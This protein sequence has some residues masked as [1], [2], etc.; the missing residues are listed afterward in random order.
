MLPFRSNLCQ[1]SSFLFFLFSMKLFS[2]SDSVTDLADVK[3]LCAGL[4]ALRRALGGSHQ[5]PSDQQLMGT[6]TVTL[7]DLQWALSVVKPSAMREVAID[8]PKVH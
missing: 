5:P 2:T 1:V 8:V 4:H 3:L 7:Q 6:V